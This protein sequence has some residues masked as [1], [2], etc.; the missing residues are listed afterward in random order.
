MLY[1]KLR[2]KNISELY[3]TKQ[4]R[5]LE[6]YGNDIRTERMITLSRQLRVLP[7]L[8]SLT[9]N[10][11]NIN[12]EGFKFKSFSEHIH[13]V[14]LLKVLNLSYNALKDCNVYQVKFGLLRQ[15]RCRDC[16]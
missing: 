4:V 10:G 7:S 1:V 11:S 2:A 5:K 16:K 12:V 15:L 9:L 3:Q 6:C 8:V 13:S 14:P